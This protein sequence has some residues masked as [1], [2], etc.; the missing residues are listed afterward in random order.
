MSSAQVKSFLPLPPIPSSDDESKKSPVPMKDKVAM[1]ASQMAHSTGSS[2][3][4]SPVPTH[5]SIKAMYGLLTPAGRLTPTGQGRIKAPPVCM[6]PALKKVASNMDEFNTAGVCFSPREAESCA[7]KA[8]I[9]D[10][11]DEN[12]HKGDSDVEEMPLNIE[13]CHA[14]ESAAA[15]AVPTLDWGKA[16]HQFVSSSSTVVTMSSAGSCCARSA[17][18]NE[19]AVVAS[20]TVNMDPPLKVVRTDLGDNAEDEHV[21]GVESGCDMVQQSHDMSGN[22]NEY[23]VVGKAPQPASLAP[24]VS[25]PEASSTKFLSTTFTNNLI[26]DNSSRQGRSLQRWLVHSLT[27]DLVRQVA[28]TIPITRDGRIVLVSASRKSEWILPKGGW[29]TNETKK[30]CAARETFEE[31]GLLGRL[32]GCLDPIDYETG[33]ARKRRL[34]QMTGGSVGVGTLGGTGAGES[35]AGDKV[36]GGKREG[37]EGLRPPLHKRVKTGDEASKSPTGPELTSS[38]SKKAGSS[39]SCS[40]GSSSVNN[41]AASAAHPSLAPA[42]STPAATTSFDPKNYSYVRLSLFPL[43]VSSVKSD[44]PEKGRVRK[45]VDI[46]EA[47]RIMEAENRP[48][49]KRGLE[50]VKE[51]GLHHLMK[52]EERQSEGQSDSGEGN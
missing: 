19:I 41:D 49:F 36:E 23:P 20:V 22:P 35:K 33:K 28:G 13:Q 50:M 10:G 44:W 42:A 14:G 51:R 12:S 18:G 25:A 47:I 29:D 8:Q 46:D 3:N 26:K 52:S 34:S 9:L 2:S 7:E 4:I 21:G 5:K 17:M 32:G 24:A 27:G 37:C 38:L 45:L 16:S 1:Y 30:E 15:G 39:D 6:A 31:G 40:S 48:Y 43:Y 11:R